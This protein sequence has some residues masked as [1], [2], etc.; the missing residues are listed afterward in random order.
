MSSMNAPEAPSVSSVRAPFRVE[1]DDLDPPRDEPA[2]ERADEAVVLVVLNNN[3]PFPG[4][5]LLHRLLRPTC[6]AHVLPP[7]PEEGA[8]RLPDL[9]DELRLLASKG[10]E[11]L[12]EAPAWLLQ[13]FHGFGRKG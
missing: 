1:A 3:E 8:S 5:R 13:A 11:A 12:K 9:E 4:E 10:G 6:F 7:L 2:H